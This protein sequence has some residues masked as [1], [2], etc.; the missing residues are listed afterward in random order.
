MDDLVSILKYHVVSQILPTTEILGEPVTVDTLLEGKSLTFD[1]PL[2][3]TVNGADVVWSDVLATNGMGH[4]ITS[5][6]VPDDL[7]LPESTDDTGG[8][9]TSGHGDTTTDNGTD[10]DNNMTDPNITMD[11]NTTDPNGDEP[12]SSAGVISVATVG[13]IGLLAICAML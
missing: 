11:D 6:L 8:N 9:T 12:P 4:I 13:T 5:V 10:M 7:S 2:G 1:R 3:I